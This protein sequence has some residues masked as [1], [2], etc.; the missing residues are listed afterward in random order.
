MFVLHRWTISTIYNPKVLEIAFV[1]LYSS[2]L[3]KA[4]IAIK[5]QSRNEILK[6]L[7]D[8]TLGQKQNRCS[9]LTN[10]LGGRSVIPTPLHRFGPLD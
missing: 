6:L 1:N 5:V 2:T 8:S 9:Q 7:D 4:V 3:Q 10:Q